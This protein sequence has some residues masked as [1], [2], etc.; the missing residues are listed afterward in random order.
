MVEIGN[1]RRTLD[2][3]DRAA[4][5]EQQ[6]RRRRAVVRQRDVDAAL[7]EQADERKVRARGRLDAVNRAAGAARFEEDAMGVVAERERAGDIVRQIR[8]RDEPRA[9]SA[10]STCSGITSRAIVSSIAPTRACSTGIGQPDVQHMPL[11]RQAYGRWKLSQK[12][13]TAYYVVTSALIRS[14]AVETR[15]ASRRISALP[16]KAI[17][18]CCGAWKKWPGTTIVS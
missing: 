14:S 16:P 13:F 5:L 15:T 4:V 9:T 6:R 12:N 1:R 2:D 17:R 18:M 8:S 10:W 7:I 3:L 11:W